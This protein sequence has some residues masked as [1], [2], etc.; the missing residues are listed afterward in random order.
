M[1]GAQESQLIGQKFNQKDHISSGFIWHILQSAMKP[2]NMTLGYP[3]TWSEFPTTY[4]P[5]SPYLKQLE[6]QIL[7]FRSPGL[8][9][10]LAQ[11]RSKAHIVWHASAI[12]DPP[13]SWSASPIRTPVTNGGFDLTHSDDSSLKGFKSNG[14]T[15]KMV[16]LLHKTSAKQR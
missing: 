9:K 13:N 11:L 10:T 1:L 6:L 8:L 16:I 12:A 7:I 15:Q 14:E 3:R 5:I 4:L 2:K